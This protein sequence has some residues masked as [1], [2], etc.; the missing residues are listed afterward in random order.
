MKK[1]IL[2]F[3]FLILSAS[4]IFA[5]SFQK[6]DRI[7][8]VGVGGTS[9]LHFNP[10][11]K[12]SANDFNSTTGL[13]SLQMEWGI[14][15]YVGLGF[16]TGIGGGSN[17]LGFWGT[18]Y[19]EVNLPLGIMSNFH[20]YQLIS[21]K[22]GKNIHADKL[23]VYGGITVGS[24]IAFF[25]NS[26][27]VTPLLYGGAHVGARYFFTPKMGANLELGYGRVFANI[28]LSFKL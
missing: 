16:S 7:L 14:H 28:G 19:G 26:S 23:D 12:M 6:G 8:S 10:G 20:F 11:K 13:L 22:T 3:C 1:N 4:S 17:R 21:D 18:N 24:G 15:Q 25:P 27:A 5:Q 2:S 9:M